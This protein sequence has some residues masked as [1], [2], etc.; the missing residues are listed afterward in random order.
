MSTA[1][2]PRP[3]PEE[4]RRR[5]ARHTD[6]R[7]TAPRR[8]GPPT[9]HWVLVGIVVALFAAA[10]A[11]G[12][13]TSSIGMPH[14][15]VEKQEDTD[16]WGHLQPIRSDEYNVATPILLSEVATG[17]APTLSPF[18]TEASLVH[19]YAVGPVQTLVF[20][21]NLPFKLSGIVPAA[22]LLAAHWWL[23]T[24]LLLLCMPTWFVLMGG[25]RHLGWVA[26][27]LV[28]AS[29]ANFWWT[30]QL[31][32]Q[33]A[34]VLAGCTAML[35]AARR[36][37]RGQRLVPLLQCLAGG[38]CIA[39]MPSNYFL[40]SILLGGG[41]LLASSVRLLTRWGRGALTALVLTGVVSAVLGLGVIWEG[42]AGLAAISS[43]EY[44]GLRRSTAHAVDTGM[45]FGS[46]V[47]HALGTQSP[48][49]TNESE[50]ATPLNLAILLIPVAWLA[51]PRRTAVRA[52]M[53]EFV[54]G[55][56]AAM[57]LVW[58]MVSIGDIGTRLPIFSSVPPERAAQSI[59]TVGI[60]ALCL[61]LSHVRPRRWGLALLA[62]GAAALI[63]LQAGTILRQGVL[64]ELDLTLLWG[65]GLV[66]GLSVFLLMAFP[67]SWVGPVVASVASIAAVLTAGPLQF[68]V[69]DMRGNPTA[70][71]LYAAGEQA[72]AD[73][74]QWV[75]DQGAF[76][77]LMTANGVPALS[78]FQRSGPD[79]E[80]WKALDPD[81]AASHSWNRAGGYLNF[82]WVEGAPTEISDNGFDVTLVRIDPCTLVS[83]EDDLTTLV[84]TVPL[85]ASP[86]LEP[87]GT[88][89]FSGQDLLVYTV[90]R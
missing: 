31:T 29:P 70:D 32:Q 41:I 90:R 40:W 33:I 12:A 82:N 60:I 10:V 37:E 45:L 48:V 44:P 2:I 69:A 50:L 74:T 68:G 58:C 84:S 39:G 81:G 9:W 38:I 53:G 67:R 83:L 73:G 76:S 7:R 61:A 17:G 5:A 21:D 19:R 89:R 46:P 75:A 72:R 22:S 59:G 11:S 15:T 80:A 20:F 47:L 14:L 63:A 51:G 18:G 28:A 62:G 64:P 79:E 65:A 36:F 49:G 16:H 88:M 6:R 77:I 3:R 52:R 54:L 57:W 34:F 24:L 42:R 35:A 13:T 30:F 23:P 56:W 66:L 25:R 55:G 86:C 8:I 43:T 26:G 4:R 27:I 87:S 71:A 85:N 78:G 1:A